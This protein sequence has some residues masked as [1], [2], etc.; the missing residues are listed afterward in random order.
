M[1]AP[2]DG[3]TDPPGTQSGASRVTALR[4]EN[5]R[6]KEES[7]NLDHELAATLA[8]SKILQAALDAKR[9]QIEA[10]NRNHRQG[11]PM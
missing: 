2:I 7:A 3:S 6:L 9:V 10:R 1:P 8:T 5:A 11:D 4:A